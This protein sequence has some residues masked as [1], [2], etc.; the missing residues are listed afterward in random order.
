[1]RRCSSRLKVRE[2]YLHMCRRG[3][4]WSLF[5]KSFPVWMLARR[6]IKRIFGI[7]RRCLAA[8]RLGLLLLVDLAFRIRL[9]G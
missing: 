9:H 2:P 3:K 5:G 8:F 6:I 4:T 7:D 1:M